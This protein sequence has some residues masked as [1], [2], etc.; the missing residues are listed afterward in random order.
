[1]HLSI[2]GQRQVQGRS[3]ASKKKSSTRKPAARPSWGVRA[4]ASSRVAR[5]ANVVPARSAMRSP[6]ENP[7]PPPASSSSSALIKNCFVQSSRPRS[8]VRAK[9]AARRQ[10]RAIRCGRTDAVEIELLP[11]WRGAK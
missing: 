2:S 6:T 10:F 9:G 11:R 7:L 5:R 1:M 4:A 3:A 8:V